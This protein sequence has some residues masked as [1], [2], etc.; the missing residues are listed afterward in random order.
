[1]DCRS[2]P[3]LVLASH[4][5][6]FIRIQAIN[7]PYSPLCKDNNIRAT[8]Q[9]NKPENKVHNMQIVDASESNTSTHQKITT[10]IILTH[11]HHLVGR[12]IKRSPHPL[13]SHIFITW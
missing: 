3:L 4:R 8:N 2:F 13:S 10:S 1:M 12:H 5:Q 9:T 6:V 11:L 7:A